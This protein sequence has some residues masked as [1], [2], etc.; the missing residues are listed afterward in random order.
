MTDRAAV[1]GTVAPGLDAV[2]DAFAHNLAEP[3]EV[4]ASLAVVCE[5][6]LV[7]DLWG[8]H[9]DAARSSEWQRNTLVPVFST[10]KGMVALCAHLLL[11]REALELDAP[12]ARY[13]PEFAQGGKSEV[14]VRYVLDHRAGLPW[15]SPGADGRRYLD[16]DACCERLARY[17]PVYAPGSRAEYHAITFG[18]LVGELVRRVTG[19]RIGRFFAE[20]VA[21]PLAA[22]FHIGLPTAEEARVAEIVAPRWELLGVEAPPAE[23]DVVAFANDPDWR[24]A[25]IPSVNG[26]GNARGVATVY[27]VLANGGSSATH[28]LATAAMVRRMWQRSGVTDCSG[29][30]WDAAWALGFMPNWSNMWGPSRSAFGHTG[31]GGSFGMAD[32][33]GRVGIAYA[34]NGVGTEW[35]LGPRGQR[36]IRAVYH[37]L[38][39]LS[40]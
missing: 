3:P 5:G 7:V 19:R 17:E 30:P 13:W 37:C 4:G 21:G 33:D 9:T 6:E 15:L 24:E 20:E 23:H 27:G 40:R 38:D 35:D 12:V 36:V 28:R 16:W 39:R 11:E 8:G 25:E 14:T 34:M 29:G 32:P 26:V 31:F 10:T 18:F 22:D 2:R 1:H